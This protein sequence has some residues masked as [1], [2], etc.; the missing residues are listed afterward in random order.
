MGGGL[1]ADPVT[2][3]KEEPLRRRRCYFFPSEPEKREDR[4]NVKSLRS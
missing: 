1:D 3:W 2:Q 4:P